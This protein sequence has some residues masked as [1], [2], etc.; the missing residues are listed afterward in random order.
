VAFVHDEIVVQA[1][2]A[3]A[4]DAAAWLRQAMI[5]GLAPLIDPVPV[6]VEVKIGRTWGG[7]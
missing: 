2:A 7:D 1:D 4:D 6:E 3:Q 5:D